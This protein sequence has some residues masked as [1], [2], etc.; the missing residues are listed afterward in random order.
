[1]D[2]TIVHWKDGLLSNFYTKS[3]NKLKKE[4]FRTAPTDWP[5]DS[6]ELALCSLLDDSIGGSTSSTETVCRL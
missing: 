4:K 2:R 5:F 1:M 6:G 3:R